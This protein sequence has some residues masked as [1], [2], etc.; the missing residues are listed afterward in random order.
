M[1]GR[2]EERHQREHEG[3]GGEAADRYRSIDVTE[4]KLKIPSRLS[5]VGL[6]PEDA[7]FPALSSLTQQHI[8]PASAHTQFISPKSLSQIAFSLCGSADRLLSAHTLQPSH[9]LL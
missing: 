2:E 4:Q 8:K 6:T 3:G 5:S 9:R 1:A 7:M